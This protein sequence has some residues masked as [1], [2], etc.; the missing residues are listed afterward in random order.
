MIFLN[1]LLKSK[2]A[3]KIRNFL[4]IKP[5]H[6][7]FDYTSEGKSV[8]DAFFWRVDENF[9]TIFRY[10]DILNIF[11]NEKPFTIDVP[12]SIMRFSKVTPF[13]LSMSFDAANFPIKC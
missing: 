1:K 5:S 8:S 12:T 7:L 9:K 4:N 2:N 13:I 6:F 3:K 10:S 11:Y